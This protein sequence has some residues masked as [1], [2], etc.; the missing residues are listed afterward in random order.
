M[1]KWTCGLVYKW[2]C[3]LVDKWTCGQVDKWTKGDNWNCRACFGPVS[4]LCWRS[5]EPVQVAPGVSE[6]RK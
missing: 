1:D 4:D 2:T 5:I 3:G 6:G